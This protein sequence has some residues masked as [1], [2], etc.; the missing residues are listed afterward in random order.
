MV[1]NNY[2]RKKGKWVLKEKKPYQIILDKAVRV[3]KTSKPAHKKIAE[4]WICLANR[5]LHKK[6]YSKDIFRIA[7]AST[8]VKHGFIEKFGSFI[9]REESIKLS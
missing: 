1:E 4:R 6:K 7:G 3:I 5:E 2:M 8:T 9:I